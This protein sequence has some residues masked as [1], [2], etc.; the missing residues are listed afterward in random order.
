MG[1]LMNRK[2]ANNHIG[3]QIRVVDPLLGSYI[4]ELIDIITEPRKPWR[5]KVKIK[6]IRAISSPTLI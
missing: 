4:G 2:E 5:G 3:K 1:L 6:A